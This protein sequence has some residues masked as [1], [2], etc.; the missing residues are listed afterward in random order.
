M[1]IEIKSIGKFAKHKL[2]YA[3]MFVWRETLSNDRYI[4][5]IGWNTLEDHYQTSKNQE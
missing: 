4:K 5:N 2:K 1:D 3:A